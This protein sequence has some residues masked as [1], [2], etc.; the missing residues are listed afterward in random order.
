MDIDRPRRPMKRSRSSNSWARRRSSGS[1]RIMRKV[2][3]GMIVHKFTRK[4]V[5]SLAITNSLNPQNYAMGWTL[6]AVPNYGEFTALFDQYRITRIEVTWIY[7]HNSGDISTAAGVASNANMGLPNLYAVAD[8]DDNTALSGLTDYVQYEPCKIAR[9]N[10]IQ[11][12]TIRP[13]IAM[14][15]YQAGTFTSYAN[16]RSWIDSASP[17]VVHF[18]LKW[19]VDASMCNP[20]NS[21][22]VQ[23]GTMNV[24]TKYWLEMKSTK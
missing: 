2:S 16:A 18:G 3:G 12:W 4:M 6:N 13:K 7:D 14:A 9:L 17:A 22:A 5:Q 19:A 10:K 1:R 20:A 8:Y 24:I 23:I 21:A 15:A 11:R